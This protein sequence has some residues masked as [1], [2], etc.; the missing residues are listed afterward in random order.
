MSLNRYRETNSRDCARIPLEAWSIIYGIE[1]PLDSGEQSLTERIPEGTDEFCLPDRLMSAGDVVGKSISIARRHWRDLMIPFFF[2]LLCFGVIG[3]LQIDFAPGA[4]ALQRLAIT[5]EV[6]GSCAYLFLRCY[7][8]V[9]C[10][11]VILFA[12][13][14]S[15]ELQSAIEQAEKRWLFVVFLMSP[16]ILGDL[17]QLVIEIFSAAFAADAGGG[18]ILN[19]TISI[20]L[21]YLVILIDI[22]LSVITVM[23][24]VF[25]STLVTEGTGIKASVARFAH[26]LVSEGAYILGVSFLFAL[27]SLALWLSTTLIQVIYFVKPVLPHALAQ[28]LPFVSAGAYCLIASPMRALIAV[29]SAIAAVW[30]NHQITM[31]LECA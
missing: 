31:R 4:V 9:L 3:Y 17:G 14:Q 6:I 26:F 10:F 11:A 1:L 8:A 24:S 20:Y 18:S 12:S 30:T 5:A 22:P 27:I 15:T 23:N 2:P 25:I 19:R 29:S 7:L 28:G 21:Y 16:S 13:G